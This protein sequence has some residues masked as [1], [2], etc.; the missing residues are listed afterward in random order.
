[1]I[2]QSVVA[3]LKFAGWALALAVSALAQS[4]SAPDA[5]AFY[6]PPGQVLLEAQVWNKGHKKVQHPWFGWWGAGGQ[7]QRADRLVGELPK[8]VLGLTANDFHLLDDGVEQSISYFRTADE[9][10]DD[11]TGVWSLVPTPY[12]I[13]GTRVGGPHFDFPPAS[14]LIGYVPPRATHGECHTI[15]LIVNGYDVDLNR[16]EYCPANSSV[17]NDSSSQP[18]P[19]IYPKS[20]NPYTKPIDV[21]IRTFT[22]WSSGVLRVGDSKVQAGSPP[23][24][25]SADYLYTVQANASEAPATVHLDVDFDG[26]SGSGGWDYPCRKDQRPLQVLATVRTLNGRLAAQHTYSYSCSTIPIWSTIYQGRDNT[27]APQ[28][29]VP[30]PSRLDTEI[31]LSPGDY[32]LEV[33]VKV[34]GNWYNSGHAQTPLHV[35]AYDPHRLMMSDLVVG[36]VVRSAEWVPRDA[37]SVAPA[38]IIPTPLVSKDLEYLPDS[39]PQARAGKGTPLYL[40]FEIYEPQQAATVYYRW[41]VVDQKTGSTVMSNEPMS[42]ADWTVPGSTVVPIGLKI[43][44]D[45]MQAG[46]YWVEMQAS[47]SAGQTS[48]WRAAKFN[49]P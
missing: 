29:Y 20:T 34:T 28:T 8:P 10:A 19:T 41:R 36:G 15:K 17:S 44:V 16:D 6:R 12:G 49:V 5:V 9:P 46:A 47:D 4:P 33:A 22:F 13:W 18:K 23:E 45:K 37:A 7:K 25:P 27:D 2:R 40:Y 32:E 21:R 24:H 38:P 3:G 48:V 1:M 31:R 42:A 30:T 39:Q 35:E 43:N 26:G 11:L 14:Y